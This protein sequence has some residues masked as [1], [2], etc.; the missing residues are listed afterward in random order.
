MCGP[1]RRGPQLI[2]RPYNNGSGH[3]SV[4]GDINLDEG[5]VSSGHGQSE[6]D[7]LVRF[8]SGDLFVSLDG[9]ANLFRP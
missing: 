1:G 7:Y 6:S 5:D 3:G 8:N 4:D 2:Y 9:I